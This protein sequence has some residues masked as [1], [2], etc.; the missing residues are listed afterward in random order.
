MCC[1]KVSN[2]WNKQAKQKHCSK[3]QVGFRA[4]S[5]LKNAFR[6][7]SRLSF[8]PT[9]NCLR[10]QTS[11]EQPSHVWTTQIW[12][13][14]INCLNINQQCCRLSF[15]K[16]FWWNQGFL[17]TKF[18]TRQTSAKSQNCDKKHLWHNS[19]NEQVMFQISSAAQL[20]WHCRN[21]DPSTAPL[22]SP[23]FW[24]TLVNIVRLATG[25]DDRAV[26]GRELHG[27]RRVCESERET[28]SG[29]NRLC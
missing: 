22:C 28:K 27:I 3:Y 2:G 18:P 24:G 8:R 19:R 16:G 4:L 14:T 9:Q 7:G 17:F 26:I 25:Q 12:N 10:W 21:G 29:N 1:I 23:R 20:P 6:K 13:I 15:W 11:Y 5:D